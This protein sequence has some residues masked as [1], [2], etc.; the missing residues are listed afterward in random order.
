M[1]GYMARSDVCK[2]FL[3]YANIPSDGVRLWSDVAIRSMKMNR[4]KD[5]LAF[6]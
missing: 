3:D 6:I 4:E 2:S 1:A 5:I